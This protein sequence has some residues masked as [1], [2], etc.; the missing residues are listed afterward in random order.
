MTFITRDDLSD[1][2]GRDVSTDDGA[3]LAVDA[4][5]EIVRTITEQD[6]D[7]VTE[8]ISVDGTGS[9]TIL[10]PQRPVSNV[11][12]VTVNGG[13]LTSDDYGYTTDGRLIRT[14]GTASFSSWGRSCLPSAYW[15][16]GRQNISVT[17]EHGYAGTVPADIRMV[18]LMIAYRIITQGGAIQEQVGQASKRYANA[19]TDLTNGEKAILAKYRRVSS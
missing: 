16:P 14:N 13:T 8:T 11:G 12:T 4:A 19:A 9:D 10:L 18:A 7:D 3:L 6:F 17:Y 5:C 2:L 1:Y 15:T